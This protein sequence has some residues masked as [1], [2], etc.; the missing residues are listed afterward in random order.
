MQE[1][2]QLAIAL[3]TFNRAEYLDLCLTLNLL[4]LKPWAIPLFISDNGSTD[5]TR[6]IVE[7]HSREYPFIHYYRN[8]VTIGPDENFEKVLRCPQT[9]YIWLLGDTYRLPDPEGIESLLQ[10]V[11]QESFDALLFNVVDRVLDVKKQVYTDQNKLLSDIGWH[12]TCLSSL[13][14]SKKLLDSADFIRYHD[15]NFLQIGIILEYISKKSFRIKWFPQYSVR[16]LSVLGVKKQS[17]ESQ[18]FEIWA[19]RW[20]NFIFSLPPSYSLNS[21]LKCILDHGEKSGVFAFSALK[22]LRKK[23]ILNAEEYKRYSRYFPFTI[24]THKLFIRLIALLPSWVFKI[25]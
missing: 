4:L 6:E 10:S 9:E 11:Q 19:M 22:R 17:W 16:G 15:T 21:K 13:V 3:P 24:K 25:L 20:A 14:Y 8:E 1:N 18:T 2:T 5:H 12:I 7:K 23:N